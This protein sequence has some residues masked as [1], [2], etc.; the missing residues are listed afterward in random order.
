[1]DSYILGKPAEA[2]C[3]DA[4]AATSVLDTVLGNST[5]HIVALDPAGIVVLVKVVPNAPASVFAE[6]RLVSRPTCVP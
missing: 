3:T 1:M 2:C 6:A 4:V 5:A